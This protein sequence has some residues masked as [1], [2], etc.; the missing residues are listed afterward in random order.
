LSVTVIDQPPVARFT[1]SC[2]KWTCTFDASTSTDD[3]GIV[4]YTFDFGNGSSSS[5]T[6]PRVTV[7]FNHNVSTVQVKLTVQDRAGQTAS[8]TQTVAVK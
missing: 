8:T 2:A 5:G 6:V 4:L 7:T 3:I 1:Y